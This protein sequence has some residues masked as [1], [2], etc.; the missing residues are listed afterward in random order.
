MKTFVAACIVAAGLL[1]AH[2]M[3]DGPFDGTWKADL[4]TAKMPKTPDVY[5]LA[6]GMYTCKTCAPAYSIK[7][8]GTDQAVAGHPYFDT[9]AIKVVDAHSIQETDKKAG[10]TVTTSSVTIA[11]D[12]KTG[13]F[14][15]TDSSN[16]NAAP[17]VGKG[18][19]KQVA[20][21][22]AG[23]HAVS[24]SWITTSFSGLSDNGVTVTYKTDG[25]MLSM[26]DPTGQSYTAKMDGTVAPF[27]G[28]PG[29]TTVSVKMMG[30]N[31]MME[32]DMRD[33]KLIGTAT[34]TVSAD[35][36]SMSVVYSDMLHGGRK[37]TY[38]AMKQ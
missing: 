5:V 3:A 35:G 21:G 28:D 6:G 2:A 22:P 16:T 10:K 27:K 26:S 17:V 1:P 31:T 14:D 15:F 25:D 23:S 11:A 19:I 20:M 29:V 32:T 38:M 24:G 7:A 30:A 34:S 4:S 12:G 8:D 36:K 9:V 33:G 13:T 37:T 18:A